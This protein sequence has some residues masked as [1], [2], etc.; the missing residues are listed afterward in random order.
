MLTALSPCVLGQVLKVLTARQRFFQTVA[1]SGATVDP[2]NGLEREK[3]NTGMDCPARP[4]CFISSAEKGEKDGDKEK[5]SYSK[6]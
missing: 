5:A 1:S 4:V 6:R 3:N 2:V